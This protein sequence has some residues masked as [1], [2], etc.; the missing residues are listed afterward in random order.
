MNL[1]TDQAKT[2]QT[3]S[4]NGSH[5]SIANTDRGISSYVDIGAAVAAAALPPSVD[6]D[7]VK[8]I[9]RLTVKHRRMIGLYLQGET[10]SE[11]AASLRCHPATVGA[12]MRNPTTEKL[13]ERAY[14]ECD[15][16]L[17]ALAPLAVRAIRDSLKDPDNKVK[18]QGVDR[19]FKATGR[20]RDDPMGRESAED[21]VREIIK[22][23]HRDGSEVTI[24]KE[25]S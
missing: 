9:K 13:L 1:L 3:S 2:V 7:K 16:R 23:R 10:Y 6:P 11:I 21:V 25:R 24:A 8:P 5:D 12:V 22:I 17:K 20:F 15:E 18:L 4:A 19:L 14:S